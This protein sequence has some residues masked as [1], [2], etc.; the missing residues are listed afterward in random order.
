MNGINLPAGNYIVSANLTATSNGAFAAQCY[1]IGISAPSTIGLKSFEN[2]ADGSAVL[3]T[4]VSLFTDDVLGINCW[5]TGGGD[6]INVEGS[7]YAI[8]VDAIA[9]YSPDFLCPT[10]LEDK[11]SAQSMAC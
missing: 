1:F 4:H 10:S 11:S 5:R 7:I 2:I 9:S 8:A 6:V 3:Q